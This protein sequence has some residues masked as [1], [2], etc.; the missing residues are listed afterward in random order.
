MNN[1][2]N[3]SL[4]LNDKSSNILSSGEPILTEEEADEKLIKNE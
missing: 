1:S 2:A 3:F 4:S